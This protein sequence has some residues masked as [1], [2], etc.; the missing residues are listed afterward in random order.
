MSK[1]NS[2]NRVPPQ[3]SRSDLVNIL[4]QIDS[5]VNN[6]SEGRVAA[7][8]NAQSSI[9]SGSAV[10]YAR[11]D[12]VRDQNVSITGTVGSQ[13]IRI[14]WYCTS[15]PGGFTEARVWTGT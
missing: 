5:Q 3:Y 2:A 10:S 6:L 9:P 15:A 14:G 1:L 4:T 12:F 13:Y 8:Y 7:A 11:G